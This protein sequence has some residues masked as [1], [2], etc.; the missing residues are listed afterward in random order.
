MSRPLSWGLLMLFLAAGA[1]VFV[2]LRPATWV[3]RPASSG[4][5]RGDPGALRLHFPS[6]VDLTVGENRL[7]FGFT[8]RDGRM[9][10]E[11]DISEGSVVVSDVTGSEPKA[12]QTVPAQ[13]LRSE[14]REVSKASYYENPGVLADGF[15]TA[16]VRFARAGQWGLDFRVRRSGMNP[17]AQRVLP[18]V[19]SESLTPSV[20]APAPRSRNPTLEDVRGDLTRL[21]SDPRLDDVQMHRMSI[22][23]V[24]K[25]GRPAVVLFASPG[26]DENRLSLPITEV[27][28]SL[29]PEYGGKVEFIHVEVYD[30][31]RYRR[32]LLEGTRGAMPPGPELSGT[33]EQWGI[34][35][36]P[37]LFFIDSRGRIF[38]KFFGPIARGEVEETLR[39]LVSQDE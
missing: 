19:L 11:K 26:L 34:Q 30:L 37:W 39:R 12:V 17:F 27:L 25:G 23:D 22:A 33:A 29:H 16:T 32:G 18:T 7:V 14:W 36:H 38:A 15:F 10:G 8:D 4:V 13:F 3:T 31:D 5:A 20:G 6:V 28:Y 9:L 24:I 35:N 2:W 1:A 21:D